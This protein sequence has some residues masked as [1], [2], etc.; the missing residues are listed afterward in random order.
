VYLK[1][2]PICGGEAALSE[3]YV[4]RAGYYCECFEC[5]KSTDEFASR[6]AAAQAW[7]RSEAKDLKDTELR[8][9]YAIVMKPLKTWW[10]VFYRS[11]FLLFGPVFS[12]TIMTSLSS[13]YPPILNV[14]M[15]L[16]WIFWLTVGLYLYVKFSKKHYS[17][18]RRLLKKERTE[19]L[20][21]T[22]LAYITALCAHAAL[23]LFV[24]I[25]FA[26]LCR[27]D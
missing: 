17:T 21:A 15:N 24:I 25:P 9:L 19:N 3:A 12:Y 6:N 8:G 16:F 10:Q 26:E 27:Y 22:I 14:G 7:N 2:C 11:F 5:G 20:I 13:D 1:S 18:V 23:I 4:D